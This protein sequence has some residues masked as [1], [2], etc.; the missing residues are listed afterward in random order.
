MKIAV[1]GAFVVDNVAT[2]EK[3]PSAGETV[4]GKNL[5]LYL[6][7][8]GANQCVSV[9]RLGGDVAMIGMVGDDENGHKFIELFNKEKIDT[10]YIF[11]TKKE[12]TGCA[13][14]QI[15]KDGQ[16]RICVIPSANHCFADKEFAKAKKIIDANDIIVFQLEM[17]YSINEKMMEYAKSCGKIVILNPAPAIKLSS[18]LLKGIDYLVP[19]ETEL[20][21]IS[22]C[23]TDDVD[24]VKVACEKLNKKGVKNIITT[25]GSR[26][27][28]LYNKETSVLVESYKVKAI[29]TVAAGDSFIGAFAYGLA[30][31]H[32]NV[33][34]IK[35]ANAMGALTVQVKG[36]IPSLHKL[37]EV[38]KFIKENKELGIKKI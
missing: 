4:I 2:M 35:F 34:S 16:N 27:A 9:A 28:Y 23:D 26:G 29:D 25:L 7:G 5:K 32:D 15:N 37:R 33:E 1:F 24:Q 14:I 11:L 21:L 17:E 19:N 13:Q 6:G 30:T 20:A 31:G 12:P 8:K 38:K 22:G 36:A 18:K 3:Y 10:K